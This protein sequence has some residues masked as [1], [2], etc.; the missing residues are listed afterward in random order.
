MSIQCNHHV[1]ISFECEK[2]YKILETLK[3]YLPKI[4]ETE[5]F[6]NETEYEEDYEIIKCKSSRRSANHFLTYKRFGW[7]DFVEKES[8]TNLFMQ[9]ERI[10]YEKCEEKR[11]P[12]LSFLFR[13][14]FE[15]R[16]DTERASKCEYLNL[17]QKTK[18]K[19]ER[20]WNIIVEHIKNF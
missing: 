5:D 1:D 3:E 10:F 11:I 14:M 13:K 9:I 19:Y 6:Q 20:I 18:E 15:L 16:G 8:I 7:I 17:K 12:N 4:N 2:C